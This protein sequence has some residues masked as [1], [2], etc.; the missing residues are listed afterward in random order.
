M[1]VRRRAW[2]V[3]SP[4]FSDYYERTFLRLCVVNP[5]KGMPHEAAD[6][7]ILFDTGC[8]SVH[9]NAVY[10]SLINGL[11]NLEEAQ[12]ARFVYNRMR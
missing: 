6:H 8:T 3:P 11:S 9:P 5:E 7:N 12:D 10:L 4:Y 2:L 1:V